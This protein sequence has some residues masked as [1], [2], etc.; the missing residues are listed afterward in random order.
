MNSSS[1]TT[2]HALIILRHAKSD[3]SEDFDGV[4]MDRPLSKRG[5]KAAKLV[6]RFLDG[7][8]EIPD[9]VLCS[10]ALRA[11]ATLNL[12][13]EARG[14]DRPVRE[15]PALYD[16]G[17]EGLIG[18][19]RAEPESTRLLMIVGHE[20][21]CSQAIRYLIGGGLVNVPT[22]ALARID[23]LVDEWSEVGATTG[24]LSWLVVPRV[25]RV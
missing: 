3:W 18:E 5:R 10:P 6:G 2:A 12:A 13:S 15:S 23:F 20:P 1:D 11:R 17:P 14:W 7:A 25:I 21:A 8:G 22:A 24:T 9:S 19:I 4:D 16:G